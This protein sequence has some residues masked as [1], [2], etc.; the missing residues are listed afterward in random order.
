MMCSVRFNGD[1]PKEKER[2]KKK[3]TAIMW[4]GY[5]LGRWKSDVADFSIRL[6]LVMLH[7]KRHALLVILY[8]K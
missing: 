6:I 5:A 7:G 4:R 3:N 2:K 1:A 8:A